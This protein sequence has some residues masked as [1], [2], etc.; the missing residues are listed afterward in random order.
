MTLLWL[1]L[2]AALMF[3]AS[4]FHRAIWARRLLPVSNLLVFVGV[5]Q[6]FVHHKPFALW[7]GLLVADPLNTWL[8]LISSVVGVA[9]T[10][11][12]TTLPRRVRILQQE[13][14]RFYRFFA[15]FWAGLILA[16]L[17]N[18][19]GLF[20]IGLELAT[21]STVYMIR[22]RDSVT[23][24]RA[25]WNYMIVGTVAISLVFFG[26]IL[27][28]ASAKP[29]LGDDAMR[30]DLLAHAVETIPSPLLFELGFAIT[31][32]GLLIKMGFVPT[33]LWL[34][35]IER[36]AHYPVAAL[37]AGILETAVMLG[38]FR[39]SDLA[40]AVNATHTQW[41]VGVL[42]LTTLTAVAAL[43]WRAKD[44]MRLFAL[45]GIEHMALVAFFWVTGGKF[46]ALLHLTAHTF[47]KPALF[48]ATG[49]M[50]QQGAYRLQGALA[51]FTTPSGRLFVV[52]TGALMLGLIALPPSP[53]FFSEL[54]G[55]SALFQGLLPLSATML[56]M[57]LLLPLSAVFYRFVQVWQLM[58][59]DNPS[60]DIPKRVETP[61]LAATLL[62]AAST[63][64]LLTPS[65]WRYLESLT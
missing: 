44:L 24:R 64:L 15:L 43:M 46:A 28:Y 63:A 42:A 18:H 52:I 7:D 37:F 39:F 40:L 55:L 5:V 48:L 54:I 29:V 62:L 25:A 26:I 57:A 47:M 11:A 12:L 2:P 32:F 58:R 21:L 53:M 16:M 19:M 35:N 17:A 30:F 22:T 65:V 23:T 56:A 60:T 13:I 31:L 36:A 4:F 34:P 38:F 41:L 49:V 45:S 9:V 8:L 51:G 20:W 50:E 6:L 14:D 59:H 10:L 3:T 61:E 33:L 27:I 1:F